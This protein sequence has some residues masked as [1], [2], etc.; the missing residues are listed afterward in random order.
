MT[1]LPT[2]KDEQIEAEFWDNH[3]ATDYLADTEEVAWEFID[4]RPAKTAIS[5]QEETICPQKT[6]FRE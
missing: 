2:F 3:D 1:K 6:F 5:I 4:E